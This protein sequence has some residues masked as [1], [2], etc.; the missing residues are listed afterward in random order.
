MEEMGE[1]FDCGICYDIMHQAV[2]IMPCVH[3]FCGG[4]FSD[5][6][7]RQK[8]CPTCRNPIDG[9]SKCAPINSLIENFLHMNPDRIRDKEMVD[10][11][12]AKNLFTSKGQ[13]NVEDINQIL[14]E[15][16]EDEENKDDG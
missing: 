4:C 5:W 8:D 13:F 15:G 12:G 10:E 2:S 16:K 6:I 14:A 1:Q 11:I 3:N 7:K 9:V